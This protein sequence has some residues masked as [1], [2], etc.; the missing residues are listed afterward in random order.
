MWH[1]HV[2]T[3]A[4]LPQNNSKTGFYWMTKKKSI[5]RN[6]QKSNLALIKNLN[7]VIGEQVHYAFLSLNNKEIHYFVL[8]LV[9]PCH[10]STIYKQAYS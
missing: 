4:T 7:T 5:F 1:P 10:A 3:T 6:I 8:P 2:Y 9:E